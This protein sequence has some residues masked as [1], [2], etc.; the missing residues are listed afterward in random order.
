M[1]LLKEHIDFSP[2]TENSP[3]ANISLASSHD[4]THSSQGCR[5]EL[6]VLFF[7]NV[8]VWNQHCL[9][10]LYLKHKLHIF[11]ITAS[12]FP[13]H[14]IGFYDMDQRFQPPVAPHSGMDGIINNSKPFSFCFF[15]MM[16]CLITSPRA[17]GGRDLESSSCSLSS[18]R[19]CCPADRKCTEE[20]GLGVQ[21]RGSGVCE[22][23]G[24]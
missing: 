4:S 6:H 7:F 16:W 15:K 22:C 13:K 23:V 9:F 2:R 12:Q 17:R 5:F 8:P 19:Q 3:W 20:L 11:Y 10:Y 18:R 1:Y 24:D 14:I 21:P